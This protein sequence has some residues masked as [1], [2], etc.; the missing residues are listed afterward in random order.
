MDFDS[1]WEIRVFRKVSWFFYEWNSDVSP[2]F[3]LTSW[4]NAKISL[5][6]CVRFRAFGRFWCDY[7]IWFRG[8]SC[9]LGLMVRWVGRGFV[10]MLIHGWIEKVWERLCT[11]GLMV[12]WVGRGFITMLILGWIKKV[13]ERLW[14]SN[15]LLVVSLEWDGI[16]LGTGKWPDYCFSWRRNALDPCVGWRDY[17]KYGM[18]VKLCVG[19]ALR[20][21]IK[22]VIYREWVIGLW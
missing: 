21:R 12:S 6:G 5:V 19:C 17:L 3:A 9:T 14:K 8:G 18:G 10:T 11:F 15:V 2:K 7:G 20:F 16:F 13:W 22:R 4:D 1:K